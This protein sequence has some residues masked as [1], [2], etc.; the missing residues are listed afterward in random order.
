MTGIPPALQTYLS[1]DSLQPMWQALR[2]RLE[3]T[4]HA[5]RGTVPV[6]L[7]DEGADRLGGLLG[8]PVPAGPAVVKLTDLDVALRASA[9]QRGLIAVVAELTG[10]PLRDRP[11]ERDADH[12]RREQ[13]WAELDRLLVANGLAGQDWTRPW[14]EWLHRGG[15]L[16]RLSAGD[17][18]PTLAVAT[19]TLAKILARTP[20]RERTPTGL[21]ELASEVTGDAHGLD[22]GTPA[23]AVILRALAFALA[24]PPAASAAERRLLWQRVGVGTDEI[25]GTVITYGLRPPGTDR[26]AG[27]MRERADLGLITHLTVHELRRASELTRLGEIVHV[28]ENPQVLQRLAAAGIDRPLACTSGNPSAAGMLLLAR[29]TVRYH[30]DFDWPGIAIARRI[31]ER[32]AEPWRFRRADYAE[33][34][35]HLRADRRLALTGRVEATPWDEELSPAMAAANTAVHEEAIVDLLLA[36]LS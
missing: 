29:T 24:T 4:G 15:V 17:A 18:G 28:C 1:T 36:G 26:W 32:D 12:A 20:D 5:I 30:G 10:G 13:L 6:E 27:M 35:D 23:A 16:T 9:A 3:R 34:V 2:K 8:R 33:A 31:I 19:R 14:T 21:A 22:D 25:S 7:D 11:A